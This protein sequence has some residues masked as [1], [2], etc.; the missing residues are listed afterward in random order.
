MSLSEKPSAQSSTPPCK[1]RYTPE[2]KAWL[3]ENWEDEY[4]LLRAYGLSIH[5]EEDRDEGKRIVQAMIATDQDEPDSEDEDDEEDDEGDP[6]LH[7]A[8]HFFTAC[9]LA[10]IEGNFG[11]SGHFLLCYGL[12][13]Y[14]DDD[15][16]EGQ[17]IVSALMTMD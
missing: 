14:N 7:L 2:E 12:K 3:K 10:W 5:N 11:S 15:C 8:D 16:E 4:H 1:E 17:R 9:E 6:I 13:P